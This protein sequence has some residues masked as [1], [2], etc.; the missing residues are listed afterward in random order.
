MQTDPRVAAF[1]AVDGPEIFRPV[2]YPTEVWYPDLLDV[3]AIYADARGLYEGLLRRATAPDEGHK[4]GR[5]LLLRGESGSGKT[6]L[7]RAFRTRAHQQALGYFG[8]MQM[9][10]SS[11]N[12]SRYILQK[13]IDSLDQPYY[14]TPASPDDTTGLMRLSTAVAESARL[15]PHQVRRLQEDTLGNSERA[16]LVLDLADEAV[17]D[18]MLRDTPIDLVRA[19]LFLQSGHPAIRSRVMKYLRAEPLSD[20]DRQRLGGVSPLDRDESAQAMIERLG[21]LMWT[22][23]GAALILCVDQLEDIALY[24]GAEEKF[25]RA[26]KGL[27]QVAA[28]VPSALIVV[29]CLEDYYDVLRGHLDKSA[30]DRIENDPAPLTLQ[31]GRTWDEIR[32]VVGLHLSHLFDHFDLPASDELATYPIPDRLLRE[33]VKQTT[34]AVLTAC[35]AYRDQCVR[36]GR[37]V[38]SESDNNE[39]IG[40]PA[41]Q[42]THELKQSLLEFDQAWNDFLAN[43]EQVPLEND[44]QLV[45]LLAESIELCSDEVDTDLRYT[46]ETDGLDIEV[47]TASRAGTSWHRCAWPGSATMPRRPAAWASRLRVCCERASNGLTGT[48]PIVVRSAEYQPKTPR[49][50]I[51]RLFAQLYARAGSYVIVRDSD[52]RTM[53]AIQPFRLRE[54]ELPHFETWLRRAQPLARLASLRELVALDARRPR[55]EST[56]VAPA[57]SQAD[58]HP[59]RPG[60]ETAA[61]AEV[62]GEHLDR[63][64]APANCRVG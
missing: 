25:R 52:W 44:Q 61:A 18:P 13:L 10:T 58:V 43:F 54:Q 15:A 24:E 32:A 19:M 31:G 41:S 30:L 23:H 21:R 5:I 33:Q 22:V 8:Y 3:E 60:E 26:I 20:H 27:T 38:P 51:A 40:L 45:D 36:A 12:Y 55:P 47:H 11:G 14:R 46:T 53:A 28:Q 1:C 37:L 56:A 63:S 34:R 59:Q 4:V 7:M 29:A 6:H 39:G 16:E 62:D 35:K 9:T 42:P 64:A 49:S 48:T 50:T 17:R 57:A 2:A